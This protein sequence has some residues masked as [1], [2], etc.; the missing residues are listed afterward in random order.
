MAATYG[1]AHVYSDYRELIEKG[2][3]DAVVVATPDDL[4]YPITMEALDAG[5]HVLWRSHWPSPQSRRARW[6]PKPRPP[7]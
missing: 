1:I 4:H 3:L 6:P 2:K 5:L 7:A